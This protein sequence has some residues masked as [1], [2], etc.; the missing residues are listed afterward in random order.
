MILFPAIYETWFLF[1]NY[2]VMSTNTETF[3]HVS[4]PSIRIGGFSVA[5]ATEVI[6]EFCKGPPDYLPVDQTPGCK[7][8]LPEHLQQRVAE[9]YHVDRPEKFIGRFLPS[10]TIQ[11]P[12]TTQQMSDEI[13]WHCDSSERSLFTTVPI[14]IG[15]TPVVTDV[16]TGALQVPVKNAAWGEAKNLVYF[17]ETADGRAAVR[18]AIS[19]GD[20]VQDTT[21]Q[22][23]DLTLAERGTIHRRPNFSEVRYFTKSSLK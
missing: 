12:G 20:L 13:N 23:G 18:D 15:S 14:I 1:Y 19:D 11:F 22:P 8:G 7:F 17:L 5:V 3:T 4:H 21:I 2:G 6:D 16:L 9:T 10:F